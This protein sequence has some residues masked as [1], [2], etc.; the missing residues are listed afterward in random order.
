MQNEISLDVKR[1]EVLVSIITV[2]YNSEETIARTIISVLQQSYKLI[3]YIIVDGASTDNTN[4]IIQG[5]ES[6]FNGRLK[7]IS[8]PDNGI[9]DAMN[10]GILLAKGDLIGIVNS[11]DWIDENTIERIVD[12]Y[13]KNEKK[14]GI[15][16]GSLLF[17]Y[18]NGMMQLMKSD[19][20]R[21]TKLRSNFLMPVRHPATYISSSVYNR[22]GLFD[23]LFKVNADKDFI[24]RCIEAN[25]LFVFINDI[26]SNMT[27]CGISNSFKGFLKGYKDEKLFAKKHNLDMLQRMK[28]L[29][30]FIMKELVKSLFPRK[31]TKYSRR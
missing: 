10:K 30:Y 14:A 4:N 25:V 20:N 5:L 2:S 23:V 13:I 27:D 12:V 29:S 9:Y 11:D 8:E 18:G 1:E 17:H 31:F 24:Y 7:Y 22:V 21:F 19:S 28:L 6:C 26:L 3:E 15:Y 16:T